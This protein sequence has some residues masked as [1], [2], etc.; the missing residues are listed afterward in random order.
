MMG[1]PQLLVAHIAGNGKLVRPMA[2]P[3]KRAR[4]FCQ[5]RP[6]I[7]PGSPF[8]VVLVKCVGPGGLQNAR[9]REKP[10]RRLTHHHVVPRKG[11]YTISPYKVT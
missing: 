7:G 2:W 1:L 9:T 11:L 3:P 8:D 5:M 4:L 6:A 10:E